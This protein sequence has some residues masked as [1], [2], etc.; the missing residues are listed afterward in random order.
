MHVNPVAI[1]QA[2][3]AAIG[4]ALAGYLLG[5]AAA[6]ALGF[7]ASV[8]LANTLL[9]AWHMRAVAPRSGRT[10]GQELAKLVGASLERFFLVASLLAAGLG[11]LKLSPAPLLAGFVLGQLVLVISSIL[12]GIE[13]Q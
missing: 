4:T 13:K 6:K 10:P 3:A 8:A 1:Y 12:S 2:M 5:E 9:L 7:G 11:W